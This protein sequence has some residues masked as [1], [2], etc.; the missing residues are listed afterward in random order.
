MQTVDPAGLTLV[1]VGP[2]LVSCD[3]TIN[4]KT[5]AMTARA[6]IPAEHCACAGAI[7]AHMD[8]IAVWPLNRH[9]HTMKPVL[10]CELARNP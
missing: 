1:G 3:H 5:T 9:D 4:A 10:L 7:G 8:G 2:Q 6:R